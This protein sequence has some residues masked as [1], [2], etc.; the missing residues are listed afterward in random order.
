MYATDRYTKVVLT[1]IAVCLVWLCARDATVVRAAY[2][3]N[4]PQGQNVMSVRIVGVNV[5]SNNPLP[6]A[7]T[8]PVGSS[9]SPAWEWSAGA[10]L[11]PDK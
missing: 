7:I 6:V 9:F 3:E 10:I 2:A 1:V 4:Q 11:R 5:A 8:I